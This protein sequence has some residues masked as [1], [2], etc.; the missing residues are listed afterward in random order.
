LIAQL[1]AARRAEPA[2]QHVDNIRWLET[3][4][5]AL[6]GYAKGERVICVVNLDPFT[7]REGVCVVPTALGL[8]PAFEVRDLLSGAEFVWHGGRNY[9]RLEPGASHLLKVLVP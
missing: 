1:N 3:E 7:V 5:E 9:V 8:P 6:I 4:N 2:L